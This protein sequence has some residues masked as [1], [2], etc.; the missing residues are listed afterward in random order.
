MTF[1]YVHVAP[2]YGGAG[3]FPVWERT[4]GFDPG[5]VDPDTSG[6]PEQLIQEF[7]AWNEKWE[8]VIN[9]DPGGTEEERLE[10]D[11]EGRAL[12]KRLRT[13]LGRDARVTYEISA[14][15]ENGRIIEAR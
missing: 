8:T 3:T 10:F 5:E 15:P 7:L 2:E 1:R 6:F 14:G 12:A 9:S 13:F 11:R 4:P